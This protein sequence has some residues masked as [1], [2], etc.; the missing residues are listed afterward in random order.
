MPQIRTRPRRALLGALVA[1]L[2]AV[3]LLA[4]VGTGTPVAQAA[5]AGTP[6]LP[7]LRTILPTDSFSIVNGPEGREFRY[8]HRI[9]NAG[10][11]PLDIAPFYSTSAGTY[12]G[13]QQVM[14]HDA[15]GN[16][17]ALSTRRVADEFKYHAEHGHFHFPLA[18]F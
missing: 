2:L 8:T 14:T 1:G 10:E 16:W 4:V 17:S 12:L 6:H 9:Y 5:P 13:R 11:G 18:S 7:D 3:G 15:G